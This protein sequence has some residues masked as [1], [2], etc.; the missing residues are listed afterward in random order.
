MHRPAIAISSFR[1]CWLDWGLRKSLRRLPLVWHLPITY[2]YYYHFFYRLIKM[3]Q[4]FDLVGFALYFY[5]FIIFRWDHFVFFFFENFVVQLP[6]KVVLFTAPDTLKIS[7]FSFLKPSIHYL[8]DLSLSLSTFFVLIIWCSVK[9][10]HYLGQTFF[11][12]TSFQITVLK[13]VCI[14]DFLS[15]LSYLSLYLSIYLHIYIHIY[16]HSSFDQYSNNHASFFLFMSN[17]YLWFL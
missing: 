10:C 9:T 16:I 6:P 2:Y 3:T 1:S 8:D 12:F 14:T 13:K 11:I 7:W 17:H 15:L 5:L 4:S